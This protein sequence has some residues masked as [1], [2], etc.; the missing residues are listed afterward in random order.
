MELG[1]WVV[2]GED[3]MDDTACLLPCLM[4]AFPGMGQLVLMRKLFDVR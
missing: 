2:V 4:V 3:N 1:G